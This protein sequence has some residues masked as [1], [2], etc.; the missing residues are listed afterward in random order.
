MFDII[1][2]AKK[3]GFILDKDIKSVEEKEF[4]R[5]DYNNIHNKPFI[6]YNDY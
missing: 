4:C 1:Y 3:Y 6:C 5:A 2:F